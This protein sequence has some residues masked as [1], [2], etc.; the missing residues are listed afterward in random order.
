MPP[1]GNRDRRA[2][3]HVPE[4]DLYIPPKGRRVFPPR[5]D[6]LDETDEQYLHSWIE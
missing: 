6:D 4:Q 2:G 5:A 3:K 1:H